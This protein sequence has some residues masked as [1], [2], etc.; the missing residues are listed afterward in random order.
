M[1][2]LLNVHKIRLD[3]ILGSLLSRDG[4]SLPSFF[5]FAFRITALRQLFNLSM[6]SGKHPLRVRCYELVV[7]LLSQYLSMEPS[8]VL[9][10]EGGGK[11]TPLKV[12]V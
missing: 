12:T 1:N 7:Q 8:Q 10:R 9:V 2:R 4:T 3:Q 5:M 11:S 6:V